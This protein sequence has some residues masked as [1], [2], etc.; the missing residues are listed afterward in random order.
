MDRLSFVDLDTRNQWSWTG[1]ELRRYG[2][3]R[4]FPERK[5]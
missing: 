4:Y 1:E 2:I 5:I 3:K